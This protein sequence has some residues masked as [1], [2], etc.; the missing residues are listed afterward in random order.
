MTKSNNSFLVANTRGNNVLQF[1]S[2]TGELIS[3]FVT[4]GLGGLSDPDTLLFGSDV[5][6]D[7][8][9]DLYISSGA[10]PGVS[11]ILRYDGT[12]GDFIDV[13]VGDDPNTDADETSGL[14]RPYGIAF[15][16]DG[17]LYVASFLSD[18]IL[19]YDGE[20]GNFI[21]VFDVGDGEP[22]GLNGPNGLLFIDDSLYVTTQGSRATVDPDTGEIFPDFSAGLPS[23]ILR[24]DSLEVGAE[25]TVFATPEP[26]PDSLD[27]VSLLGLELGSDGDLYVSDFAND[28]LRYD[29]KTGEL[30]D[31]LSTNYTTDTPPS[32]NFIGSLAFA[33]DGDLLTVGFDIDTLQGAVLEFESENDSPVEP[34]SLLV[35]PD[36][37]LERPVGITFFPEDP[38]TPIFGT[39]ESDTV[40]I[41]GSKQL[42]FAGD[43]NDLVDAS[44]GAGK[45]RIYAGSG[46]D[47]LILGQSDR[48]FGG[49]GDDLFLTTSNGDNTITGGAGADQ[50]WIATASIPESANVITDFAVG[51]DVIGIA[52]LG[53]G[54]KDLTIT[55]TDADTL[56]TANS[57]DDRLLIY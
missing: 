19:R 43:L 14:V 11:S 20:T 40:E 41:I 37:I 13:F 25:P 12:N 16:P 22:G 52:G 6:G 51:E 55:Q 24:Y 54:F 7:R 10:E 1:D 45:N 4:S 23:Q 30:V 35:P 39:L 31:T 49:E 17:D 34:L 27:F 42:I 29:L 57:N 26:S 8:Q 38:Q 50:F 28:I 2:A 36:P 44:T 5:N 15:S 21:N 46:D 56:I 18:Q 32:N 48:L 53:V 47:T 3:E 33:P 9:S